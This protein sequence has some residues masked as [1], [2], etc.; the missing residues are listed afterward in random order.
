MKL[1][2][3]RRGFDSASGG[4]PSPILPDG[5]MLALPIPDTRS[6][7]RYCDLS[8]NGRDVGELVERLT[9]GRIRAD[10]GAHLDPDLRRD[11]VRRARGWRPVLGQCA[12]A[13]GHLH[14]QAV[15]VGDVFLFWGLFRMVD[16]RL[17][18]CGA[19]MHA[20]RGWLE[21]GEVAHVDTDVRPKLEQWRWAARHPHLAFETDAT[22]TLYVAATREGSAGFFPTYSP[23]RRLTAAEAPSPSLWSVPGWMVPGGRKPLSYHANA[24]RWSTSR[25]HALLQ[26]AAR[27]QEF[28]LDGSLYPEAK[29]WL[30]E[31]TEGR[32]APRLA[33][34]APSPMRS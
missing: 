31:L 11:V 27:G 33:A 5:A 15:G 13:Q 4:C 28:V 21:V 18:W 17:R 22:N 16:D 19:P 34:G 2:L 29:T 24:E 1:I 23:A 8:W 7:V 30:A 10:S 32:L 26:A 20:I 25:G 9:K 12:S 3:S 6:P 14:N